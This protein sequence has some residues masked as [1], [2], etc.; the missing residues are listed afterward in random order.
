MSM[1]EHESFHVSA[2]ISDSIEIALF[3]E[4]QN[5]I[6]PCHVFGNVGNNDKYMEEAVFDVLVA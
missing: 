6:A 4:L 3:L 5:K 1:L 2:Y